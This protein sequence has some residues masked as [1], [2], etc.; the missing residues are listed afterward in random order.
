MRRATF[1]VLFYVKRTKIKKD[2]RLPIYVRITVNKQ[3]AEFSA[4]LSIEE[5]QWD[6]IRGMA[7]NTSKQN[8]EI[9]Q[10]LEAL[11]TNLALKKHE[12]EDYGK[13]ISANSLKNGHLGIDESIPTLLGLFKDHNEKCAQL[14]NIDYSPRTVDKYKHCYNHVG[15][16]IKHR[17]K[18]ND[19]EIAEVNAMFVR[20]LEHYLKTVRGCSHN[21]SIKYV[22]NFKKIVR[23]ALANGWLKVD[24]FANIRYKFDE[25]DLAYLDERELKLL[26]KIQLPNNRMQQVKD[27]YL[28]CCFTGLA[29][30]D[31]K[32][33]SSEDIVDNDGS[34]W[35]KKRRTKT[36]NW[37]TVPLLE[38][39]KKI[40]D[41]YKSHPSCVKN[42]RLLPVIS[43]QKMN[44]YL[45][46]IAKFAGIEKHLSTHTARHT[47]ATTVTL[48]NQVSMEVVSKMLGHSSINMT[49]RYAR[50]ADELIRK[51]MHKIFGKYDKVISN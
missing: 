33:L 23:I 37:S 10:R 29:F 11:K 30:V 40:L 41:N 48:G 51:D 24:P 4:Q 36:K 12:L 27:V 50:V 15:R 3:R 39:A 8:K 20:D 35:I 32:T 13:L 18:K 9:N 25:V 19:V 16:F 43:N 44:S 31:A 46:E 22:S 1:K 2:G 6:P 42:N 21:T 38:P 28:F 49:K 47:F 5:E 7:K 34:Q 14:M 45:K 17:Y 26:M